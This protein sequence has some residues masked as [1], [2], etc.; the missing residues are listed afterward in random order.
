MEDKVIKL[1]N[2]LKVKLATKDRFK[3]TFNLMLSTDDKHQCS[4]FRNELQGML[5]S[6]EAEGIISL[7]ELDVVG[8]AF[9]AV[10]KARNRSFLVTKRA[11]AKAANIQG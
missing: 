6:L 5:N 7:Y 10:W 11:V 3:E 4:M 2:K 1:I 8:T 9:G